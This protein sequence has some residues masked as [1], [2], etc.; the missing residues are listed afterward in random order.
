MSRHRKELREAPK[1]A[2]P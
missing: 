1:S 2:G